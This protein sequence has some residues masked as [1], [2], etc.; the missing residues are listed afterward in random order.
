MNDHIGQ[1]IDVGNTP[2]ELG[3]EHETL[4]GVDTAIQELDVDDCI[5]HIGGPCACRESFL[6]RETPLHLFQ[7]HES[8][9][10]QRRPDADTFDIASDSLAVEDKHVLVGRNPPQSDGV[11]QDLVEV[12]IVNELTVL[13]PVRRKRRRLTGPVVSHRPQEIGHKKGHGYAH[14]CADSVF[15]MLDMNHPDI[16]RNLEMRLG[17]IY[18]RGHDDQEDKTT[19]NCTKFENSG[20]SALHVS[21]G[22]LRARGKNRKWR[23]RRH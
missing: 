18:A 9:L 8:G 5:S 15:R 16:C 6:L 1:R 3:C 11:G 21:C 23:K 17:Y 22:A 19:D 7:G 2:I 20:C 13:L 12:D 4:D 10:L 14:V